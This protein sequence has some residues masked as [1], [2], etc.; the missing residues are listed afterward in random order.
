MPLPAH[1][2]QLGAVTAYTGKLWRFI[3]IP[4]AWLLAWTLSGYF[5]LAW[6]V[7]LSIYI[8]LISLMAIMNS[9]NEGNQSHLLVW[10]PKLFTIT[11]Q[12]VWGGFLAL[13]YWL[14]YL[15]IFHFE[16]LNAR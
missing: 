14:T 1:S 6:L 11:G 15:L 13:L 2:D 3:I 12:L 4:L 8:L 5:A 10:A 16:D 7:A 9:P